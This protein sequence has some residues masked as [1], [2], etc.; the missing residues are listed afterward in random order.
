MSISKPP[1]GTHGA[2]KPSGFLARIFMPLAMRSHRRHGDRFRD[3]DVLYLTTRGA[4]SGQLRT[5]PVAR[6]DDGR[7]GWLV[8]ASANGAASHPGWYHNVVAHP[9]EVSIEFGGRT[10][11]VTAEQLDGDAREQAWAEIVRRA[12][13]FASYPDKTDRLIPVLRLTPV[14]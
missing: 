4:K 10:Q 13:G 3:M 8:V 5:V 2:R 9:D 1:S 11:R 6:F 14:S 7:G 12:P